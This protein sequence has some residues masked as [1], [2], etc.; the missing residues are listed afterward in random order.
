[1]FNSAGMATGTYQ[2]RARLRDTAS[3]RP[4]QFSV[5]KSISVT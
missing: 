2:F 3:G 5:A 4:P 1:M